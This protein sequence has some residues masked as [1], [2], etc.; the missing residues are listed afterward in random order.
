[1]SA[2]VVSDASVELSPAQVE[3]L[4]SAWSALLVADYR[5]RHA[6]SST[7]GIAVLP[8]RPLASSQSSG[9]A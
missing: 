2:P 8:S 9:R 4:V 5:A 7:A 6:T 3:A 1:M